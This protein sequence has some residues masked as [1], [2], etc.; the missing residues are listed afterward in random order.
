M[1][2]LTDYYLFPLV[3][4]ALI[5]FVV[6]IVFVDVSSRL[7]KPR[8]ANVPPLPVEATISGAATVTRGEKSMAIFYAAYGGLTSIFVAL[9]LAVPQTHKTVFVLLDVCLIF[10]ACLL[11]RWFRNKLIE[12]TNALPTREH[13]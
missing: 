11:N 13:R 7:V 9:S 4:A 6:V 1:A 3:Q 2:L 12:W 10:Y 5:A 8:P